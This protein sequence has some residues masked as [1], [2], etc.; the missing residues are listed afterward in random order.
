[1][2]RP[3][4]QWLEKTAPKPTPELIKACDNQPL[5][6]KLLAIRGITD[7]EAARA[8]LDVAQ[9]PLASPHLFP[10]MDIAISR[11]QK[12]ITEQEPILVYGDFDVDGVTGTSL[13]MQG[14]KALGAKVFYYI[15]DR[16]T[17]GHGMNAAALVRMVSTRQIKLVITTDNGSSNFN[18]VLMLKNLNVE[19]NCLKPWPF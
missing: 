5:V 16:R 15:P 6:A 8:F 1:V 14:L 7:A 4:W 12:A 3:H 19:T 10:G 9:Q 17:E 11:I 18:E 2:A 13:L